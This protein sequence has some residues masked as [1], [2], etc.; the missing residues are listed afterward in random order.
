LIAAP[1]CPPIH[2]PSGHSRKGG[3][4]ILPDYFAKFKGC[5]AEN[6]P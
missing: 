5:G 6:L 1:P 3:S 2:S 4:E